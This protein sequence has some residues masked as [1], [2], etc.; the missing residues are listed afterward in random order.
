MLPV[1]DEVLRQLAGHGH[2]PPEQHEFFFESIR[3]NV[4]TAWELD[5]L[6]K[7]GL[8]SKRSKYLAGAALT[9]YDTLGNLNHRERALIEGIL[10]KAKSIFGK[11]S[12][13]G[14][15]GL[16]QTAY[17]LALL[18]SLVAGKPPPRYPSQPPEPPVPGRRSGTVKHWV[19]QNFVSELSISTSVAG[20]RL[21]LQKNIGKGSLIEAIKMLA[22]H[23]P[24]GFVPAPLPGST[25]QRLKDAC[26]RTEKAVDELEQDLSDDLL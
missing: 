19:F 18:S 13:G 20:G 25:L 9:L 1:T 26:S 5:G 12:S 2:V 21:K 22:S 24:A 6:V 4:Q 16:E 17:Q 10:S 23:L 8:A 3:I 14:V 15:V 11:I 7:Q